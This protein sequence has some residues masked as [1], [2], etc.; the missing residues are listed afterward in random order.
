VNNVPWPCNRYCGMCSCC[1]TA[2]ELELELYVL[3]R[4][5]KNDRRYVAP[6][7][8]VLVGLADTLL[9]Q[10]RPRDV[11]AWIAQVERASA[12][13]RPRDVLAWI[14]RVQDD[15]AAIQKNI[16]I[17]GKHVDELIGHPS[18]RRSAAWHVLETELDKPSERYRRR[19]TVSHHDAGDARQEALYQICRGLKSRE[20]LGVTAIALPL[21]SPTTSLIALRQRFN[22][23]VRF[24][25][26]NLTILRNRFVDIKRQR[27]HL[28]I[29][30]DEG[31]HEDEAAWELLEQRAQG[32]LPGLMRWASRLPAKPR[33]LMSY[34]LARPPA[35]E[36][37]IQIDL[38]CGLD[39]GIAQLP[40]LHDDDQ[41]A[42][43]FAQ[44]DGVEVLDEQAIE[45]A[46]DNLQ[47][48][49]GNLRDWTLSMG[50]AL[51]QIADLVDGVELAPEDQ[52]VLNKCFTATLAWCA[53]QPKSQ[54][55]SARHALASLPDPWRAK[56]CSRKW[57]G[58][59]LELVRPCPSLVGGFTTA[60]RDESDPLRVAAY[61]LALALAWVMGLL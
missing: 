6:G 7:V 31:D 2:I 45:K 14:A 48:V 44:E 58:L 53:A 5:L 12:E 10:G 9:P 17:Q 8:V 23:A 60:A 36:D 28:P 56:A 21:P 40:I 24:R 38:N 43:R 20:V 35:R 37:A 59:D 51:S 46:K 3:Q 18:H 34:T 19:Y 13:G 30:D 54:Y 1:A 29:K 55:E 39:L 61:D 16:A 52:A 25:Y 49:R 22:H 4:Q 42:H 41:L 47:T 50:W 11:L 27:E 26:L 32:A 33:R 15:I 57:L